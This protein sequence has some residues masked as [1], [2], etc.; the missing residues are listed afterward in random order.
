MKKWMTVAHLNMTVPPHNMTKPQIGV[1]N[2]C[3]KRVTLLM[4]YKKVPKSYICAMF[5]KKTVLVVLKNAIVVKK[6]GKDIKK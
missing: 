4:G 2:T 1:H 3:L 5:R 6:C